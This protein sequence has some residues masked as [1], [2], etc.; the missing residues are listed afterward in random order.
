MITFTV[1]GLPAPGGSKRGF[2][3]PKLGRVQLVEACK[4]TRPW[5]ALVS[6]AAM[7]AHQAP[8]L[9]GPLRLEVEFILPRPKNHTG[10]RGL[11]AWAPHY[12]TSAPDSTKLLR[13][14]EDALKGIAW[15]DDAQVAEQLVTK[16]Y[17]DTPGAVVRIVPLQKEP[18]RPV[19]LAMADSGQRLEAWPVTC[20]GR[21]SR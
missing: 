4:R 14:T 21:S 8:P 3:N 6:D 5:R 7:Q 16:R 20:P 9:A 1:H 13:S 19:L 12:H 17:G 15:T 10:K 18:V 2:Y 11:K